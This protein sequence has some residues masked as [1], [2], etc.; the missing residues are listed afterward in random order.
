MPLPVVFYRTKGYVLPHPGLK[1]SGDVRPHATSS[2]LKWEKDNLV[3]L[4]Y[5]RLCGYS[6]NDESGYDQEEILHTNHSYFSARDN[7][8]RLVKRHRPSKLEIETGKPS[9]QAFLSFFNTSNQTREDETI[10][11]TRPG[12][13]EIKTEK[14]SHQR[15]IPELSLRQLLPTPRSASRFCLDF[16]LCLCDYVVLSLSVVCCVVIVWFCVTRV[17]SCPLI[18]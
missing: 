16:S 14:Q 2:S 6:L 18:C 17:L 11:A 8:T 15:F 9:D 7:D 13:K 3:A 12:K 4:C 1:K 5:Y 10:K